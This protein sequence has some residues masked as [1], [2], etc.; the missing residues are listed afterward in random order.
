MVYLLIRYFL[1]SDFRLEINSLQVKLLVVEVLGKE[2][3][4][5]W[6]AFCNL[7]WAVGYVIIT[8][9]LLST[10]VD[11]VTTCFFV[12]S[13]V[14]CETATIFDWDWNT[15]K[16]LTTWRTM[17]AVCGGASLVLACACALL[18][19]S[20]RFYLLTGRNYMAYLLLKQLYAINKS[21]FA[22]NFKVD[23]HS[24]A[25]KIIFFF[26]LLQVQEDNLTN[27][28]PKYELNYP[29]PSSLSEKIKFFFIRLYKSV[30]VI[31]SK[32]FRQSTALLM[33]LKTPLIV[34]G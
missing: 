15:P 30:K 14:L 22:D 32:P 25:K 3:R 27:L 11:F 2:D 5:F 31:F 29:E 21:N 20:P 17:F 7:F 6:M 26:K 12:V 18:E 4:G 9:K 19:E 16:Q 8:C 23:F 13:V 28:I 10:F 33:A 1:L 24:I 34:I